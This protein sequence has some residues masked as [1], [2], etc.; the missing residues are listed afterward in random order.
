MATKYRPAAKKNIMKSL[1]EKGYKSYADILTLFDVYTTDD[2][3]VV[4]YMIPDKWKIVLNQELS[5]DQAEL[6]TRHEIMHQALKHAKKQEKYIEKNPQ[7]AELA[8]AGRVDNIAADLDISNKAYTEKDKEQVRAIKLANE[9]VSGLVTEDAYPGWENYTFEEMYQKLLEQMK[10]DQ[11]SLKDL[12]DLLD[13]L[14][15]QDLDDLAKDIESSSGGDS[16]NDNGKD[17]SDKPEDGANSDQGEGKGE[18]DDKSPSSSKGG[19][20]SQDSNESDDGMSDGLAD[21]LSKDLDN[22]KKQLKKMDSKDNIEKGEFQS[23]SEQDKKA[24]MAKRVQA[25][26]DKFEEANLVDRLTREVADRDY[27]DRIE[28]ADK[29]ALRKRKLNPIK[30][31]KM[32][33]DKFISDQIAEIEIDSYR[34]PSRKDVDGG[35][36]LPGTSL[37]EEIAIPSLNVYHDVSGSFSDPAKTEA[38]MQAIDSLRRY[39]EDGL[40]E[41]NIKYFATRVSSTKS[42]AGGG[43][44]GEPIMEDIL[45]DKPTNV[46]IITDEDIDDISR[47]VTVPG[48]VWLLFYDARSRNLID[49][50]K[51][52]SQTRIYD[53]KY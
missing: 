30:Y 39:E 18:E 51:G 21:K 42:N 40:L 25:I 4:G 2:P 26:K 37:S 23:Q 13:K 46:V 36:I 31:F 53:I 10:E 44:E 33:L 48:A 9:V 38:A 41:I 43:T 49:H 7:Y 35:I 19:Q 6:I 8:Q 50:L 32:D 16:S 11:E 45:T 12:M 1:N 14:N 27:K 34:R 52:K 28:A 5:A 15:Q 17:S 29:E 20:E 22:I 3:G 47:Q 24:E